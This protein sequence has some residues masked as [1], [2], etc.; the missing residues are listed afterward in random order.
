MIKFNIKQIILAIAISIFGSQSVFAADSNCIAEE[1]MDSTI[2]ENVNTQYHEYT[3]SFPDRNALSAQEQRDFDSL[4]E[5]RVNEERVNEAIL[6]VESL[7]LS[8]KGLGYIETSCLHEL[9]TFL[10]NEDL[11]LVS[12]TVLT[13]I[14]NNVLSTVPS[15]FKFFGSVDETSTS[16]RKY[17]Y[18][19]FSKSE[20]DLKKL[21]AEGSKL[22]SWVTGIVDICM[23][24][25]DDKIS[26]AY[27][28]V[29][30][31]NNNLPPK[32]DV[33]PT[34]R[35]DAYYRV[36]L[37]G[38]GIYTKNTNGSW[39]RDDYAMVYSDDKG[40][41]VPYV[42][43]F[44]KGITPP[45]TQETDFDPIDL[46]SDHYNNKQ[47]ILARASNRYH[48]NTRTPVKETVMNQVIKGS[49]E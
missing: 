27:T 41:A 20:V 47:Y 31:I 15:N 2:S 21:S 34:D 30:T 35:V 4:N 43:T 38:R 3:I 28:V 10:E 37:K 11:L 25:A 36:K 39:G 19:T 13:P 16:T 22:K 9:N 49:L 46:I 33:L 1:Y 45:F 40:V 12:Y 14:E 8:E 23:N 5:E 32:Y 29:C 48:S 18:D 26:I 44:F 42:I 17:Y 6:Y 24:W 7:N